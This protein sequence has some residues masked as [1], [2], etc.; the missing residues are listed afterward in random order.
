MNISYYFTEDGIFELLESIFSPGEGSESRFL[1]YV[2]VAVVTTCYFSLSVFNKY[3]PVWLSFALIAISG[4]EFYYHNSE[5]NFIWFCSEPRWWWIVV[6]FLIYAFVCYA[7][8][9]LLI[10]QAINASYGMPHFGF[11]SVPVCLVALYT[12][13]YL[14]SPAVPYVIW[15]FILCQV[16]QVIV[17]LVRATRS[18]N[19][20][21]AIIYSAAYTIG[22]FATL[23]LGY[24][25]LIMLIF[26]AIGMCGF[27][28]LEGA[29]NS[30]TSHSPDYIDGYV[31]TMGDG[32][33][34]IKM[35]NGELHEVWSED[36]GILHDCKGMDWH[37]TNGLG[38]ARSY[39]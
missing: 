35:D 17:I 18:E 25:L 8:G 27:K 38:N 26:V 2:I 3:S 14:Y 10:N 22:M 11:F 5:S 36:K 6:N 9:L 20:L 30:S 23:M 1:V 33:K 24:H 31:C 21:T 15:A 19:I 29:D 13:V 39:K 32:R 34:F 28:F 16:I 37:T 4:L 12:T 7:Q